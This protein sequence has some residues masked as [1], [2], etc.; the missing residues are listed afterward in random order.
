LSCSG[1]IENGLHTDSFIACREFG[2]GY[3]TQL[4]F[5]QWRGTASAPET[6]YR[7]DDTRPVCGLSTKRWNSISPLSRVV[8]MI[9]YEIP[10]CPRKYRWGA[11]RS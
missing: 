4:G 1:D 5:E 3:S 8:W 6:P 11:I 7:S 2:L 10:I 9:Y